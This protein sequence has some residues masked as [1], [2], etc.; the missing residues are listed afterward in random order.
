MRKIWRELLV[1]ACV[2]FVCD[3]YA[4]ETKT[5]PDSLKDVASPE[6]V[7]EPLDVGK[8]TDDWRRTGTYILLGQA[9]Q[10][11]SRPGNWQGV[12]D[13]S[14]VVHLAWDDKGLHVAV[15][16][17][18]DKLMQASPTGAEPWQGDSFELFFNVQP[19][20]QQTSCFR[21][22]AVVPSFEP[23]GKLEVV[24]PQGIFAGVEGQ[25]VVYDKGY[26]VECRIP[27]SNLSPFRPESGALLGFQI[28]LDD[29]D[30]RGRKSQLCWYPSAVTYVQPLEMGVL[31][32]G[33]KHALPGTQLLAG[34]STRCVTDVSRMV[35]SVLSPLTGVTTA[36][37]TLL[38]S[39]AAGASSPGQERPPVEIPIETMGGRASFGQGAFELSGLEGEGEFGVELLDANK[40]VVAS[41]PF[42]TELAG[43]R[44]DSLRTRLKT[45]QERVDGQSMQSDEKVRAE[46]VAGVKFWLWRLQ[47]LYGN[48]ARPECLDVD[49]LN[50]M[51]SELGEVEFA[52]DKLDKGE[53]P[54]A[55]RRGSFVRAY[56]SPLTG[57]FRSHA[58]FVPEFY[59]PEKPLPLIIL[60]HGIF[61]DDR[62]L[63][64]ML[65]NVEDLGALVY[66]AASYRQFDW[67]DVSAAETWAGLERV[68]A[69]YSVDCNRI[70][71][72]GNHIGGRGVLQLAMD[73]PGVFAALGS[74][75]P[76]IDTHLPYPALR[77]YPEYYEAAVDNHKPFPHFEKPAVPEPLKDGTEKRVYERESLVTRA[78]NIAGVPLLIVYGE[79]DPDAAAE[80]MALFEKCSKAGSDVRE[81]YV[82]GA[83]H[84]SI[85]PQ[86][87][88]PKFY[89]WLLAQKSPPTPEHFKFVV[90]DLRNNSG[91]FTRID[92]LTSSL[93]PG[94]VECVRKGNRFD[95]TTSGVEALTPIAVTNGLKLGREPVTVVVDG[96]VFAPLFSD[97]FPMSVVRTNSG[98]WQ[99]GT[100]SPQ[101]KHHGLS[102]PIDDFQYDRFL[103]VYGTQ[104]TDEENAALEKATRKLANRGLGTEFHVKADRDVAEEDLKTS[105]LVLTG[106]P[107][108]NSL[109]A[110]LSDRLPLKW[111]QDGLQV[112]DNGVE[113]PAAAACMIYPN[114]MMPERYVVV[115]TSRDIDG[116]RRIWDKRAGVDFVL[117]QFNEDEKKF[118]ATSF[119]CFGSDWGME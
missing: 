115:I 116:Y 99:R 2:G 44:Y 40:T 103:Y 97:D 48:E 15:D 108:N 93:A 13:N 21:Q 37:I 42:K 55:D 51:L 107:S 104:G 56:P 17:I 87:S 39:S 96:V 35:F 102:G 16:V 82:P 59:R 57:D 43:R 8:V 10:T 65:E 7:A 105:H 9:S 26:R 25:T 85:P 36:R 3:G 88:D 75:Y 64:Q 24:C 41:A 6:H 49:L 68:L 98:V 89:Q 118:E 91:W 22:I 74:L 113:G 53:D 83:Q 119:G 32:L 112:G 81:V 109:L 60:L 34:P 92:S 28:L 4:S 90:T 31:R 33:G 52:I 80:R 70:Y 111:T 72:I 94:R 11:L 84:G 1:A 38:K 110:R 114:P 62:H 50:R 54:Y 27:W 46:A 73:R 67:S 45:A 101:Y 79:S 47:A 78:D 23:G 12:S 95:F 30:S 14:A 18:D 61:G 106:T 58:L 66:Q 20:N 76:G 63:F 100:M 19:G 117:G 5:R 29:R 77:L 69:D 86:L 71:L